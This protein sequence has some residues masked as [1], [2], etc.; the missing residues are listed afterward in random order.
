V[1]NGEIGE[2]Y[3]IGGHN[4]KQNLQ[5]VET[6][7]DLLEELAPNKPAGV[8]NYKDLI[9]HVADRPGHDQRYAID[10]SKIQRELDWAPQETF[11]SGVRKTVAWYLANP[12]WS[13]HILSG[14]YRLER[15]GDNL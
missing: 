2:T 13:Q 14:E 11:E 12:N 5:V 1:R 10:A 7:C 4:E 8:I 3:N 9:T 15:I 6:I